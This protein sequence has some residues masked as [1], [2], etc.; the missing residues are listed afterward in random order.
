[1]ALSKPSVFS[2]DTTYRLNSGHEIPALGYGVYLT[3]PA[4][5]EEVTTYALRVGYRHIDSAVAYENEQPC[6]KA[7]AASGLKREQVF[8][9]TKVQPQDM[10]YERTALS[11]QTS[12]STTGFDYIDLYLIHAPFG[13]KEARLGTW[14]ALSEAR[15]AG[16]IRSIGVSN[17]GIH[18]LEELE[19]YIKSTGSSSVIDVGQWEIHPWLPRQDIVD[20]CGKRNIV[21][22]AYCPVVRGERK[23]EKV[24]QDLSRKKGK[25]WAQILLRWSLQKGFVPLPKSETPSRIQ[26]NANLYDFELDADDMESL[27]F[28]TSYAPCA[29]DPTTSHD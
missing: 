14:R 28:P 20:W 13:G 1:M 4:T 2:L 16:K 11:I 18:H 3:P 27:N 22:E 9:T 24:L 12:L 17:Y 10:G 6:A 8:F 19:E 29:W 21:V 15:D 23:D 26:D 25:T 7:V 5:C